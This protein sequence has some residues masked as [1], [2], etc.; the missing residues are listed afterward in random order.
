M[1]GVNKSLGMGYA[2][3]WNIAENQG[4]GFC[5]FRIINLTQ[6]NIWLTS[7]GVATPVARLLLKE[8]QYQTQSV[9]LLIFT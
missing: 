5:G 8:Y 6:K 1:R 3:E 2:T 4:S 7:M 9:Y